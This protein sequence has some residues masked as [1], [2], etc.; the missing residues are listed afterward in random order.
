MRFGVVM[1]FGGKLSWSRLSVLRSGARRVLQQ[2][3]TA[4]LHAVCFDHMAT[5]VELA[6]LGANLN[7]K[8]EACPAV[9][10]RIA[11]C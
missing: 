4:L 11:V 3:W 9:V 10:R 1:L 6:R 2:G 7:A 8:D 5:V